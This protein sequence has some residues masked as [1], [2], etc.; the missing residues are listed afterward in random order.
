MA[1]SG[2]KLH[3]R[4]TASAAR[5]ERAATRVD[6]WPG[7]W[8]KLRS[9]LQHGLEET[10]GWWPPLRVAYRWVKRVPRLLEN[11][12]GLPVA[13]LRRRL[14]RVVTPIRQAASP[15]ATPV[16][17]QLEHFVKVT[18]S[19]RSGWCCGYAVADLPRTNNDWEQYSAVPSITSGARVDGA[20]R[21]RVWW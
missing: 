18:Q 2:L 13:K 7:G 10:A 14:G 8:R 4:L 16:R 5:L 17:S 15:A 20:E 12:A 19:Y 1:A 11:K 9:L 21:R 3:E 6:V